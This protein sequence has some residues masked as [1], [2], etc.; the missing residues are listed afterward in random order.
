[1]VTGIVCLGSANVQA[2][3][4]VSEGAPVT[5]SSKSLK[6]LSLEALMDLDITTVS[7]RPEP[8]Q[9]AAAAI[10][11]VTAEDIHRSGAT[12][13]PEALRLAPNLE[14]AQINSHDWAI[15]ARGF[16]NT[17]ANKLLVMIDGRNIY[18]PLYAGVFWD[19][20]AV[21]LEDIDRIEVVSGPG[22]TLWGANAVNGVINIVTKSSRETQ[23]LYVSGAAG[24]FMQDYGAV[25]YGG[26][27]T[28]NLYYRVYAERWDRNGAQAQ[29][30]S[31]VPD[32]WNFTQGGFRTDYY[33][34]N[35]DVMT[36]QGD[37]YYGLE[38]H[39][40]STNI[41]GQNIIGRWSRKLSAESDLQLQAYFDRTWRHV[42]MGF[43]E[44]LK[45]YDVDFQHRFQLGERNNLL[46][47]L[48][49]RDYDDNTM[50]P[51]G[52]ILTFLDPH[53]NLQLFSGFVQD[54]ITIVP[55]QVKVTVGTKL[56]HN[57]FSGW[58]IQPSGRVAWT[59]N[60]QHTLWGAIS[61]AVRS[62]SRIDADL[63]ANTPALTLVNNPNFDSEK[64][65]AFELGYRFAPDHD[66]SFS[67]STFYNV[68]DQLRSVNT[69]L[70]TGNFMLGN[71]FRGETAGV[72]ISA[73]YRPID[74]WR[75]R[76]G[77][78]YLY[79][80]LRSDGTPG[81]AASVRE[82]DD[83]EHQVLVQ[84]IVDLPYHLQF[85]T[86]G[87]YVDRLSDPRVPAYLTADVRIGWL[88]AKNFELSLVAQNLTGP[89]GE[90]SS[91]V[92]TV[93]IP[94]SYYAMLKYRY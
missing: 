74:N 5:G 70:A 6:H 34:N 71:N 41:N 12:S 44:D 54:E 8:Y 81:V 30:G 35:G 82:G 55:D 77:Y 51:P 53:R 61:R 21:L 76:G 46:W 72:E 79:K 65:T 94:R 19:A 48:E 26:M 31:T 18:T 78:T 73:N 69:N 93:D 39:G 64:L 60:Q 91:G 14:V 42:P 86:V 1:V 2:Q 47:G 16:N 83:P 28:S 22:G 75:L 90:F 23:G 7:R 66:M 36:V 11:V 57:D 52:A 40:P 17:T 32:R 45:T 58:E 62:P 33:P 25:R 24:T 9:Q 56:E 29:N 38:G 43:N 15:S 13:L 37:A 67:V 88:F 87:R 49:Y 89:H 68:Y 10:Q 92:T 20:Q 4:N 27:L 59:P 63:A 85:D 80:H 84:S 3:T 50:T